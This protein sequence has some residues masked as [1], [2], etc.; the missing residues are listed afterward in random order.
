MN[1]DTIYSREDKLY[2]QHGGI[3]PYGIMVS[4]SWTEIGAVLEVVNKYK[5]DLFVEIGFHR[6]GLGTLL[7]PNCLYN[8]GFHYL[9][10][11]IDMEIA[12]PSFLEIVEQTLFA[13]FVFEDAL[14]ELAIGIVSDALSKSLHPMIY[15]D[16]GDK[17]REFDIFSRML[18]ADGLVMVHD[19]PIEF[20]EEHFENADWV[21]RIEEDWLLQ[22]RQ[23]LFKRKI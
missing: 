12:E 3:A 16:G 10:F 17:P 14:S 4:H 11:D 23:L 2:K 9:G 6:G 22:N 13:R 1:M 20:R 21:E 8:F 5:V 7:V 18:P 19:Y 15:C